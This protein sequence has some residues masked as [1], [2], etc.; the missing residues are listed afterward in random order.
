MGTCHP[1]FSPDVDVEAPSDVQ[2]ADITCEKDEVI[3][4]LE[5][6]N[7][8]AHGCEDAWRVWQA[9]ELLPTVVKPKWAAAP[10]MQLVVYHDVSGLTQ[11][12]FDWAQRSVQDVPKGDVRRT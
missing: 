9:A 12:A 3:Q 4:K 6:E 11:T 7:M 5:V 8:G 10:R 1:I 2:G